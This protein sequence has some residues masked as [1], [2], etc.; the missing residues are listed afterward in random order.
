MLAKGKKVT[1]TET[2]GTEGT[3]PWNS[4]AIEKVRHFAMVGPVYNSVA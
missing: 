4:I 3:G 1:L 2:I